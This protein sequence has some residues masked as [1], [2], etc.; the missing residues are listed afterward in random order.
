ML[1]KF[2]AKLTL[3]HLTTDAA[4]DLGAYHKSQTFQDLYLESATF[5]RMFEKSCAELYVPS[6]IDSGRLWTLTG[7]RAP[8]DDAEEDEGTD[9]TAVGPI[10][11]R[12]R[13]HRSISRPLSV[14]TRCRVKLAPKIVRPLSSKIGTY[15]T[16]KAL[17]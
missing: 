9:G 7:L 14:F 4:A 3:E 15:K 1:E 11:P 6:L 10:G 13:S 12:C 16:V 5:G 17:T 8:A 2:Y